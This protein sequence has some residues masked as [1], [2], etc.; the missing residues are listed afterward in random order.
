M[1]VYTQGRMR[2]LTAES[3]GSSSEGGLLHRVRKRFNMLPTGLRVHLTIGVF[4]AF[5]AFFAVV[6]FGFDVV[7]LIVV[8]WPELR[9]ARVLA[10]EP[11]MASFSGESA[12]TRLRYMISVSTSV[13]HI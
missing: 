10:V 11:E 3:S 1:F 2:T 8:A 7:S 9:V 12:S 4:I 6:F 13:V 5:V